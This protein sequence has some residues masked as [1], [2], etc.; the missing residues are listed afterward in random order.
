[1]SAKKKT[2]SKGPDW[3]AM[4]K[5]AG[6]TLT[7]LVVASAQVSVTDLVVKCVESV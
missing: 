4:L 5:L 3:M 7:P 1:M 2:D 6:L